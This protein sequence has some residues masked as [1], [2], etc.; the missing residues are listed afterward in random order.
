[1]K[2]IYGVVKG[3]IGVTSSHPGRTLLDCRIF[4]WSI[5]VRLGCPFHFTTT[6]LSLVHVRRYDKC[7][8]LC[9]NDIS[10]I[11]RT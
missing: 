8:I 5:C 9:K 6:L 4:P 10:S 11:S 2:S 7:T 1:M 3:N